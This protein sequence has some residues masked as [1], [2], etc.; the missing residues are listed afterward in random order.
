MV[1]AALAELVPV[2]V[3][4]IARVDA[5]IRIPPEVVIQP[6]LTKLTVVTAHAYNV[7]M[8]P[9]RILRLRLTPTVLR[10]NVIWLPII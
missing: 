1:E 9:A 6:V 5:I 8:V 2:Q 3:A 7:T 4:M 10:K